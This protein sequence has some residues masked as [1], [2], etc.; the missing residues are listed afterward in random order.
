MTV[1][2]L[3]SVHLQPHKTTLRKTNAKAPPYDI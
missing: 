3:N 2:M 1:P